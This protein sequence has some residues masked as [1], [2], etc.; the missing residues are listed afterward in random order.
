VLVGVSVTPTVAGSGLTF[1][2]DDGA[3]HTGTVIIAT[4]LSIFDDWASASGLTGDDAEL[5]ADPDGDGLTNLQEFAFGTNPTAGAPGVIAYQ[6]GGSVTNPGTPIPQ[7]IGGGEGYHAISDGD[8]EA[9]GVSYPLL[10][11][12]DGGD[13]K[14]TFFRVGVSKE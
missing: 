14:P 11:P 8:I 10:V 3:G 4:I 9:V 13:R 2:V 7:N 1:T 12:G 5:N 6:P